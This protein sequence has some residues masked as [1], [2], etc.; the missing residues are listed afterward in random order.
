LAGRAGCYDFIPDK[1]GCA[2]V[3]VGSV[4]EVAVLHAQLAAAK[5]R[6]GAL[7]AQLAQAGDVTPGLVKDEPEDEM[8][9]AC[10]SPASKSRQAPSAPFSTGTPS[11]SSNVSSSSQKSEC[12][13]AF[14]GLMVRG[15]RHSSVRRRC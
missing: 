4:D 9:A 15:N 11:R 7:D 12:N 1:L 5:A 10:A 13:A 2:E 3:G 8:F 14:L 6:V